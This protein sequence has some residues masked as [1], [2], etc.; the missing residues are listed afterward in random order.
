MSKK[1]KN[2]NM[3]IDSKE[4]E[5]ST[6]EMENKASE[7]QEM[8]AEKVQSE[9]S[10]ATEEVEEELDEVAQLMKKNA[11]LEEALAKEKNEY[12]FLMAEF[13]NFR[14][15]TLKEKSE[16][17]KN[18][19]EK[20][21]KD[22]LPV[23]DDF[24]RGIQAIK[25]GQDVKAVEEGIELIYNKFIKYLSQNG[26]AAI[27]TEQGT[28]FDT[29][30]HEAVTM[31]PAPDESL[32]GKVVDTVLKGYTLNDKILRHAKVVVGQ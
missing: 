21:M 17:I 26:V 16:I 32:K 3:S 18:G 10:E 25:E 27:E 5:N 11:E 13:D 22:I 7:E 12:L 29:E 15:R 19:A 4:K 23:I 31:F 1:N 9:D 28:D 8:D 14:K 30:K 6:E 24:E 20:A 2:K